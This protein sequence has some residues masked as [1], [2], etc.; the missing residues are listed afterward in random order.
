MGNS[1]D[2]ACKSSLMPQI[3]FRLFLTS[4]PRLNVM[5]FIVLTQRSKGW[6]EAGRCLRRWCSIAVRVGFLLVL[7]C[8]SDLVILWLQLAVWNHMSVDDIRILM[9]STRL[10]VPHSFLWPPLFSARS[11]EH[12]LKSNLG[13]I[14]IH[15]TLSC[16]K[17]GPNDC[18]SGIGRT[19]YQC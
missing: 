5:M 18:E 8:S 7:C 17:E 12:H 11:L 14:T 2:T 10:S 19:A 6:S 3:V 4:V 16:T 9:A 13:S 15:P 1:A